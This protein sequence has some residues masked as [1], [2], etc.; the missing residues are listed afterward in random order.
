[1]GNGEMKHQETTDG[2]PPRKARG[3]SR[4]GTPWRSRAMRVT[5][6][7]MRALM[8]LFVLAVLAGG[9]Y[10][11]VLWK[12]VDDT[13]GKMAGDEP[14][15]AGMNEPAGPK[16][17]EEPV[18][19]L[20][21]GLDARESMRSLNTDVIMVVSLNPQ[22]KQGTIV[23]IPR[24]MAMKPT[25]YR[26]N[27]ANQFYAISRRYGEDKPGGSDGLVKAMFGELLDV[28]VDH[29][30]V[31][32]FKAFSDIVDAL[33][34]IEVDVD[35]DMCYIDNADGT[36]IRL[37][38]GRQILNGKE[39]LD[40]VRYRQ[41]SADC[42]DA[43]T[44]PSGDLARNERQQ[45]VLKAIVDKTLSL[46]TFAK[47]SGLLDAVGDNVRTDIA[48]KTRLRQL[49]TTYATLSPNQLE[50][51]TLEGQWKSPYIVVPESSLEAARQ[52]LK[53]RLAGSVESPGEADEPGPGGLESAFA[54]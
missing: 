9:V 20:L 51:I 40:F 25:G 27:K 42:G 7:I 41:S 6:T 34:G 24:D 30:V 16:P 1:M 4:G 14:E 35:M 23:S 10:L 31:V 21:F 15:E 26:E 11:A 50:A 49:F 39:A 46:G 12:Q 38:K 19:I 3:N 22:Q 33:G 53:A 36:N 8:V 5:G 28:K 17:K 47:V 48:S 13:L 32:D 52:A 44:A 43:R 29:L 45:Q 54:P 18:T 37:K 2:L